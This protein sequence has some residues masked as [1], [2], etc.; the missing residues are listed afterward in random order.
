VKAR[1]V[2]EMSEREQIERLLRQRNELWRLIDELIR[3]HGSHEER[4]DFLQENDLPTVEC[5]IED[6]Q[7]V[8]SVANTLEN[9]S[10]VRFDIDQ[11]AEASEEIVGNTYVVEG[12]NHQ[13]AETNPDNA[14]NSAFALYVNVEGGWWL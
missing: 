10:S 4:S 9:L 2:A 5:E 12:R 6:D 1:T 7:I 3:K 11:L 14:N 13:T 8:I